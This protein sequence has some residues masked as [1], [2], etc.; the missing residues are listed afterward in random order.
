MGTQS[1]ILASLIIATQPNSHSS[2]NVKPSLNKAD[3]KIVKTSWQSS[4]TAFT[5]FNS[6]FL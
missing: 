1:I 6:A 5:D 3:G 2:G 4:A